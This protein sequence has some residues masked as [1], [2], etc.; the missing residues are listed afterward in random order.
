MPKF[1][2]LYPHPDCNISKLLNK[3]LVFFVLFWELVSIY[4][5]EID[6]CKKNTSINHYFY[7]QLASKTHTSLKQDQSLIIINDVQGTFSHIPINSVCITA[8]IALA[9]IHIYS[10][11]NFLM[12]VKAQMCSYY[13]SCR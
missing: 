4:R 11:Y 7:S 5:S 10:W 6:F 9:R 8:R 3:K 12:K 13:T 2:P 1:H